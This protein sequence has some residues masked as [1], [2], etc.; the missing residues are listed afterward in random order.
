MKIKKDTACPLARPYTPPAAFA[1]SVC[2]AATPRSQP[3]R[4][5]IRAVRA[6]GPDRLTPS[7]GGARAPFSPPSFPSFLPRPRPRRD[8]GPGRSSS[9][10]V[11]R[12]PPCC[13]C[14][15]SWIS[16]NLLTTKERKI[17]S[18]LVAMTALA[19]LARRP[20]PAP[21]LP[22]EK[23]GL[24]YPTMHRGRERT[25][26]SADVLAASP[27]AIGYPHGDT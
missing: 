9:P 22:A 6:P 7:R 14:C 20:P 3:R 8:S 18:I 17:C 23:R 26:A 21:L 5:L 12:Y 10:A 15:S 4:S 13:C 25:R 19:A 24:R 16:R 27:H 1:E 2:K 11:A